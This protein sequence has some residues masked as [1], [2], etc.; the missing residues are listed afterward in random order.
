M[1]CINY[2]GVDQSDPLHSIAKVTARGSYLPTTEASDWFNT[3]NQPI[4]LVT[5]NTASGD[6]VVGYGFCSPDTANTGL[7][8]TTSSGKGTQRIKIDGSDLSGYHH[9]ALSDAEATGSTFQFGWELRSMEDTVHWGAIGITLKPAAA[10]GNWP[11]LQ[12]KN[13]LAYNDRMYSNA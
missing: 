1:M 5:A 10:A 7:A 8:I 12:M 4:C 9:L 2:T 6:T 3:T 11:L 13:Q